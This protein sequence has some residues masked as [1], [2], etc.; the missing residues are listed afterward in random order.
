MLILETSLS[1][2]SP[3]DLNKVKEMHERLMSLQKE[4]IKAYENGNYEEAENLDA[5]YESLSEILDGF[6]EELEDVEFSDR[7]EDDQAASRDSY[8]IELE[9]AAA[10]DSYQKEFTSEEELI[11][12][13][14]G[15]VDE[16][17]FYFGAKKNE[18]ITDEELIEIAQSFYEEKKSKQLRYKRNTQNS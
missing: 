3:K 6:L 13:L 2:L 14:K 12:R 8:E 17:S 5:E 7:E 9:M 10:Y 1:D 18:Q 16:Y 4:A 11:E 15:I